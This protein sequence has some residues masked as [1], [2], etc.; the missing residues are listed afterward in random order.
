ME[1]LAVQSTAISAVGHTR[2][3]EV[4]FTSG[5]VYQFFGVPED[6]YI[7]FLNSGSKG[8]FFNQKIRGKY[9]SQE[10]KIETQTRQEREAARIA[11]AA[12][13]AEESAAKALVKAA[14]KAA[15]AA[16]RLKAKTKSKRD[17]KRDTQS[18]PPAAG[19]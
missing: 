3:L 4:Q 2:V 7:E 19:D 14:Q 16:E 15:K 1:K 18:L 13:R 5:K 10:I 17:S 11:R 6:L 12:A 8:Q 9:P